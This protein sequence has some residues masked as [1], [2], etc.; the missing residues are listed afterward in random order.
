MFFLLQTELWYRFVV[1]IDT[2]TV[3]RTSLAKTPGKG[4]EDDCACSLQPGLVR[5]V[6]CILAIFEA[7]GEASSMGIA[8][9]TASSAQA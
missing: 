1:G 9:S 7:Q 2:L 3:G 5:G 4:R 6:A 8:K